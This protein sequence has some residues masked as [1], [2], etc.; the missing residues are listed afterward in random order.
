MKVDYAQEE[1]IAKYRCKDPR[2]YLLSTK[3]IIRKADGSMDTVVT[4]QIEWVKGDIGRYGAKTGSRYAKGVEGGPMILL[5]MGYLG[6][7]DTLPASAGA[8]ARS[9]AQT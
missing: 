1:A 6:P 3:E 9:I 2:N 5:A 8:E 7:E 4:E